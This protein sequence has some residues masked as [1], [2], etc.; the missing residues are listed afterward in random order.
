VTTQEWILSQVP[1]P[2]DKADYR[3]LYETSP[4]EHRARLYPELRKL[5]ASGQVSNRMERAGPG[6]PLVNVVTR[7]GGND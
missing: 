7:L 5:V 6:E 2:G 3:T 4:F 1:G